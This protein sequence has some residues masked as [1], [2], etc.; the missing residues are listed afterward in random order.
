MKLEMKGQVEQ[1]TVGYTV[2][3]S[4]NTTYC[5]NSNMSM[6]VCYSEHRLC[7]ILLMCRK[8]HKYGQHESYP[9]SIFQKQSI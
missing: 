3:F 6:L 2:V 1:C 8:L 4:R 9:C 5:R 7:V